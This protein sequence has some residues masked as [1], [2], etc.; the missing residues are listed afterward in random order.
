M[1]VKMT[2]KNQITIPKAIIKS[3]KGIQY[4]QIGTD[5]EC[6][7]LTPIKVHRA[8]IVRA[9]LASMQIK[10]S[11]VKNAIKWVKNRK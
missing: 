8:D 11:N 10:E 4:F 1:L 3:F 7:I 2:S 9:K 5:N 6:I